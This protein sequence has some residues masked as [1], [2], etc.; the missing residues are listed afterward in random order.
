MAELIIIVLYCIC[1]VMIAFTMLKNHMYAGE[2]HTIGALGVSNSFV[3]V[4]LV[5]II[6]SYVIMYSYYNK[7]KMKKP[8]FNIC[9][10]KKR[11]HII[12]FIFMAANLIFFL[13]TGVGRAV[14]AGTSKYSFIFAL[15]NMRALF[16]FYYF[17]GREK[18][19]IYAVNILLFCI[20]RLL[21]GWS[22]FIFDIFCYELYFFIKSKKINK[23]KMRYL[24]FFPTVGLLTAGKLYQYLYPLRSYIRFK[25]SQIYFLTYEEG[26]TAITSR[27][28]FFPN[29]IASFENIYTIKM[30]YI[31]NQPTKMKEILGML[32]PLLPSAVMNKNFETLPNILKQSMV[33]Y[34]V[35]GTSMNNGILSYIYELY[36]CDMYS[37]VFWIILTAIFII[38]FRNII[39]ACE[40]YPGQLEMLYFM[41][42]LNV[43][44]VTTLE[45]VFS[46]M[47]LPVFY[48]APVLL[49]SGTIKIK[50]SS[51]SRINKKYKI[52]EQ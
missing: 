24:L 16:P 7:T 43:V 12:F 47:Y 20:Y 49:L 9:F 45:Q 41:M 4:L 23:I 29:S 13:R 36:N 46:N 5:S 44:N 38:I 31:S 28:S 15:F 6:I 2:A 48:F 50:G 35:H 22:A 52:A 17:I 39:M 27:L 11:L 33:T 25:T 18:K 32:R 37:F 19:G 8:N 51:G 1:H 14:N 21:Q 34:D 3:I 10:D 30:I 40:E 42:L 26:L